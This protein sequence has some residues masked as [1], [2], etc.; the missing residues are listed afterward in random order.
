MLFFF[1]GKPGKQ[2]FASGFSF[3]SPTSRVL[4]MACEINAIFKTLEKT[5]YM[6]S[7]GRCAATAG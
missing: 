4:L 5:E 1:R 7:Q 6:Y 2:S 3:L